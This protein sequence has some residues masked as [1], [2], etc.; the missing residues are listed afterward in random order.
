MAIA[1]IVEKKDASEEELLI[2]EVSPSFFC[3]DADWLWESLETVKN[4]KEKPWYKKL[5]SWKTNK[6][7]KGKELD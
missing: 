2:K 7:S 5:I 4:E 3:F 6:E 1:A